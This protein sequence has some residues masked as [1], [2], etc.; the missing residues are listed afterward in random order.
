MPGVNAELMPLV[1]MTYPSD[2]IRID[3][4][5]VPLGQRVFR[6]WILLFGFLPVDYDDLVFA[7]IDPGRGFL[8]TSSMLTQ[9]IWQHERRLEPVEGGCRVTDRVEF[10]PRLSFLGA[11]YLPIF[12][13]FFRHRHRRLARVFGSSGAS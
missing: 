8:E 6:S 7:R 13:S 5:D 2:R 12:R 3:G 4:N 9:R 1:R 10:T 11:L